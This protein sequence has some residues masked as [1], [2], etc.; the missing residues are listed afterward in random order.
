M[1][2]EARVRRR[3]SRGLW[4]GRGGGDWLG[5]GTEGEGWEAGCRR[6]GRRNCV[7]GGVARGNRRMRM[8]FD[9]SGVLSWRFVGLG[10]GRGRVGSG[11]GRGSHRDRVGV[12][13]R[14]WRM[15]PSLS[16]L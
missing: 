7:G 14:M 4:G 9:G 8:S 5:R 10:F 12:V 1:G 6:G 13:R 2:R 11:I 15:M 16:C 3:R